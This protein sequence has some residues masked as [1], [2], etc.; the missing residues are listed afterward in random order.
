MGPALP[1]RAGPTPVRAT[2]R[3]P[4]PA[5]HLARPIGLLTVRTGLLREG[6]EQVGGDLRGAREVVHIE[7]AV[8]AERRR[9]VESCTALQQYTPDHAPTGVLLIKRP[10]SD[11]P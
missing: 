7:G 5:D 4:H 2:A 1:P 9:P 6:A 10:T 11:R 8:G 3:S